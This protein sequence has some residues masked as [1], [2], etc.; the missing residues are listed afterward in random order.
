VFICYE[1]IFPQ[2][3]RRLVP[4]G[5]GV[6]VNISDDAW[7][8]RSAARFQH[9]NMARFRAIENHRYL[10]RATND[11]I[12]AA[13]DPYGRVLTTA[14][15]YQ[16]SVLAAHFSYESERTFYTAHGDVFAWSCVGLSVIL[17][18]WSLIRVSAL[19]NRA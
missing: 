7:Y 11:G 6:L 5:P 16:Q 10:L 14:P 8:G 12:T 17:L 15:Q 19:G 13:V 18:I 1:A 4:P 2:L 9:L 3:V